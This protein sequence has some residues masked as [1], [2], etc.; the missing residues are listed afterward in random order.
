MNEVDKA[1]TDN[2]GKLNLGQRVIDAV[3]DQPFALNPSITFVSKT[4]STKYVSANIS[5]N[6]RS[7]TT[8]AHKF[9]VHFERLD[10]ESLLRGTNEKLLQCYLAWNKN[11][12]KKEHG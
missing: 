11:E 5:A 8:F 3:L 4:T 2:H 12:P 1:D 7:A 10:V 6:K 9:Q